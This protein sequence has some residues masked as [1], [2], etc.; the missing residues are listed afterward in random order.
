MRPNFH[1][2]TL[3]VA[4][5]AFS[6][7]SAA[8]AAGLDRSGQDV[9]AFLQDGTYAEAVYTYIDADVTGYDNKNIATNDANYVQGRQSGDIAES[10]D[11]FRYGV[12]A[13]VNKR[14][15]V[16]VLYDEPW[17]ASA[18]YSGDNN[19][20]GVATV[21][22]A[23]AIQQ[24]AN[25]AIKNTQDKIAQVEAL[26]ANPNPNAQPLDGLVYDTALNGLRDTLKNYEDLAKQPSLGGYNDIITGT[27]QTLITTETTLG[28]IGGLLSDDA[29]KNAQ[30]LLAAN[31]QDAKT[32][33]AARD[34]IQNLLSIDEATNVEVRSNTL[35]L[36]GG[37]K[38]GAQNQFQVYGGPVA[39]RLQADV[40][41]RGNAY[42]GAAGY[43]SHSGPDQSY[44]WIA[45]LSYSKPE[46]ALKAALT[47]R[48]EIDHT[49]DIAET[50]PGLAIQG[51]NPSLNSTFDITTPESFNFDFQT[52]VNPT[53]LATAKVRYV[54]WSDFLIRPTLYTQASKL[55]LVD[56]SDDQWQVE[57]GLG[58]RLAPNFAVSGSVGWDSGAGDPTSSLGP[59]EGYYSV[60]LGA[61]YDVTDNWAVSAGGKY[62]WFGD[63][64]GTLPDGSIVSN[65]KDNEGYI[66]GVKLSY[67]D[68]N[69]F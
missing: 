14:F 38:F 2:K 46:I 17:G 55:P 15:S 26:K 51:K 66:L 4:I 16:G 24:V 23:G 58:K 39:Q 11:F 57:L 60:G 6:V 50:L 37:M 7:A 42:K 56:Y 31:K 20:T 8:S 36:I 3:A 45:G 59:V 43:T 64:K 29:R 54:P 28:Q 10:Y 40:K 27:N 25:G 53:T 1:L 47:Y 67:Q 19:F 13:D 32:A 21:T 18:K 41:L 63:A 34:A 49:M 62:L 65:F 44:G 35:T 30:A 68:K 12:K 48:S 9:T 69:G 5:T 61:K 52:G 33:E 22:G